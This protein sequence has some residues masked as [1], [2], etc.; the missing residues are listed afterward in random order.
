MNGD[1][2]TD[3]L[4]AADGQTPVEDRGAGGIS[5]GGGSYRFAGGADSQGSL[6]ALPI[7]SMG[8]PTLQTKRSIRDVLLNRGSLFSRGSIRPFPRQDSLSSVNG[9]RGSIRV[10]NQGV[11]EESTPAS[12]FSGGMMAARRTAEVIK[13]THYL[14][15]LINSNGNF[16][17]RSAAIREEAVEASGQLSGQL[18]AQLED[19]SAI[20]QH[21]VSVLNRLPARRPK[22]Q[23]EVL[24]ETCKNKP[25]FK[26]FAEEHGMGGLKELLT[27]CYH[28]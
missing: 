10:A 6:L 12:A 2:V 19:K 13:L 7:N 25:F 1:N 23:I 14:S 9:P 27:Q 21:I 11:T 8:A 26:R 16:A 18:N 28:E 3:R 15:Q 5:G 4:S 24:A 20:E 22:S 17:A